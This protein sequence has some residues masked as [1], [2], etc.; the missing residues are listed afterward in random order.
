MNSLWDSFRRYN[1]ALIKKFGEK[2]I[3]PYKNI[4]RRRSPAHG[5]T[6]KA[7]V[8]VTGDDSAG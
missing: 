2:C 8:S 1:I 3:N 4:Y 6:E 5:G 7:F